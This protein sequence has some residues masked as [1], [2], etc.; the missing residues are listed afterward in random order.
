MSF[1]SSVELITA[2]TRSRFPLSLYGP[3]AG[4]ITAAALSAGGA[5]SVAHIL[6]RAGLALLL[7]FQFRLWDDL[8]DR[9]WDRSAHP[10]RVLAQ[11]SSVCAFRWLLVLVTLAGGLVVA[12]RATVFGTVWPLLVLVAGGALYYGVVR[13]H[14]SALVASALLLAKYPGFVLIVRPPAVARG[15]VLVAATLVYATFLLFELTDDDRLAAAS[16]ARVL[17]SGAAGLFA[18]AA[19]LVAVTQAWPGALMAGAGAVLMPVLFSRNIPVGA[20]PRR[21]RGYFGFLV[22]VLVVIALH[23]GDHR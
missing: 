11:A 4:L 15:P 21:Y 1:R 18:A 23:L 9:S 12:A 6:E 22:C 10:E 14:L 20:G 3:L 16:G 17:R 5:G 19:I 13:P 7:L 8:A 2:W